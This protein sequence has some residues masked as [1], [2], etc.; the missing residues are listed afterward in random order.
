[1]KVLIDAP[2]K[3]YR[4]ILISQRQTGR[5]LGFVWANYWMIRP[6]KSFTAVFH[7]QQAKSK[8]DAKAQ[9]RSFANLLTSVTGDKLGKTI[10]NKR[11]VAVE[12]LR[13]AGVF[14]VLQL[15]LNRR[16]EFGNL[17]IVKPNGANLKYFV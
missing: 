3:N 10:V 11:R 17:T 2:T 4:L 15:K 5:V 1:M 7:G 8:D 13:G 16:N 12:M 14:A 9:L 6:S